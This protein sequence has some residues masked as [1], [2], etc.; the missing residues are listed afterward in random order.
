MT[1][2]EEGGEGGRRQNQ[3]GGWGKRQREVGE[4][5]RHTAEGEM[6]GGKLRIMGYVKRNKSLGI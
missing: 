2:G 6:Q 5:R 4:D 3:E 1:L